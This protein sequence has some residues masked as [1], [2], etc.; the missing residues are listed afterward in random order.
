MIGAA[1][2]RNDIA[3]YV[4]ALFLVYTDP[5]LHPRAA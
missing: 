5:D 3:D 4:G 2:G 1:I